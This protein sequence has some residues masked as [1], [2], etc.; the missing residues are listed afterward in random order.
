MTV[1]VEGLPFLCTVSTVKDTLANVKQFVEANLASG[2]DHMFVFLESDDREI[3]SYL[4]DREHVTPISTGGDYWGEA[5]PETLV[6]RQLV[7]ANLVNVLLAPLDSVAWLVHIDGDECLEIDKGKLAGLPAE[8]RCIRLLVRE[9]VSTESGSRDVGLFKKK[10]GPARLEE[11]VR[12]GVLE[13]PSNRE[14][15]K[16]HIRGKTLARPALDLEVFVHRVARR[17]GPEPTHHRDPDFRIL[18]YECVSFDEFVRKWTAHVGAGGAA[19]REERRPLFAA[20][21]RVLR[22]ESL[23][24]DERRDA[25]LGLY[26][27]HAEDPVGLLTELG[28]LKPPQEG[29]HAYRP[30]RLPAQDLEELQA[31]LPLL[32]GADRNAF[33][34]AAEP[35]ASIDVMLEARDR[36]DEKHDRLRT[37][38]EA[39]AT[40]A[41]R[42]LARWGEA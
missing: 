4:E 21:E 25:L 12:R 10:L 13:T 18:H 1:A 15:I 38:M 6:E 41:K 7:N 42:E 27:Q 33:G 17:R 36:L 5:R 3:L 24:E 37:R 16:G 23:G 14:W 30:G 8:I 39:V 11:L 9:A 32:L 20:V 40:E 34:Q 31:L 28:F 26:K 22:D 2:A 35:H 29:W 19:F